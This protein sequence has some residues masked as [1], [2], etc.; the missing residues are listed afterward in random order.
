MRRRSLLAGAGGLGFLGVGAVAHFGRDR[1]QSTDGEEPDHD[2]VTL[3]VVEP[4]GSDLETITVPDPGRITFVDL[5]ATTCTTCQQQMPDLAKAHE[6]LGDEVTFVSITSEDP[7][8]ADD[9]TVT[10]WWETYEG[11]WPA[12]RDAEFSFTRYY[13]Q[14]TPTAILFDSEGLIRW[15]NTGRKT[16]EEVVDRVTEIQ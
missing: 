15:E 6:Q 12:A 8:I 11:T 1:L 14:A 13:R 5:F 9:D 7:R 4:A 16:T 10:D 2:P 3:S